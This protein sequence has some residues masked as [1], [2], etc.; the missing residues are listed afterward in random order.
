MLI[1]F[2][3]KCWEI[4]AMPNAVKLFSEIDQ[5]FL[6]LKR[7]AEVIQKQREEIWIRDLKPSSKLSLK[8]RGSRTSKWQNAPK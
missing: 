6:E 3:I 7:Q 4:L 8:E 1:S 2:W 5:Q